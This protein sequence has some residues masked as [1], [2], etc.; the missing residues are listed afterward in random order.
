MAS[1]KITSFTLETLNRDDVQMNVE[2]TLTH[3]P[4]EQQLGI[5]TGVWLRLLDRDGP[6]DIF[7]LST[8][9]NAVATQ[10]PMGNPDDP[11]TPWMLAGLYHPN[12]LKD[13]FKRILKRADLKLDPFWLTEAWYVVAISRPD[14][15]CNVAY[16]EEVPLNL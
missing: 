2:F 14:L 3:T 13:T 16:S 7:H 8:S 1:V 10:T 11:A 15:T 5:P 12:Q 9:W 6:R 4:T